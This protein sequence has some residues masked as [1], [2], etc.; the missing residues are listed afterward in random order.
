M[1]HWVVE[2]KEWVIGVIT[3]FFGWFGS[4]K[5]K[6]SNEKS[7]ELENLKTIREME[8]ELVE[9]T[10]KQV[11]ELREMVSEMQ[12]IIDDKDRIISE[13]RK[14]INLQN[15]QL[16]ICKEKCKIDFNS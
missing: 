16:Q 2:N 14:L 8:K 4:Q 10:K 7:A 9:D 3:G 6:K 1:K 15:Q 11:E 5:M 13:Q 12:K